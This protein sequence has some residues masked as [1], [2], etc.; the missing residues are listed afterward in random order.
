MMTTVINMLISN[1]LDALI[2]MKASS[3]HIAA[4]ITTTEIGSQHTYR[5]VVD[6]VVVD[7][8]V[9]LLMTTLARTGRSRRR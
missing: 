3:R 4:S 9:T 1:T 7:A 8:A 6:E 5:S 2:N